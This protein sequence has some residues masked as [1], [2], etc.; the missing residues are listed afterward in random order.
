VSRV[1]TRAAVDL[2][3]ERSARAIDGYP[4]TTGQT[5][6]PNCTSARQPCSPTP[7]PT[8]ASSRSAHAA[9]S[10]D[11]HRFRVANTSAALVA[12][13]VR[14]HILT[15]D[16]RASGVRV[17]ARLVSVL[18][19]SRACVGLADAGH[20]PRAGDRG[21]ARVSER[22]R[23]RQRTGRRI[24]AVRLGTPRSTRTR[25][26]ASSGPSST[27]TSRV[28][29]LLR[30]TCNCSRSSRGS[31]RTRRR[32]IVLGF[33]AANPARVLVDGDHSRDT[34]RRPPQAGW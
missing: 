16:R 29:S 4:M 32:A 27:N 30:P 26:R 7:T 8:P 20:R 1:L 23:L 5:S 3:R 10:R 12:D 15:D 31:W 22:D 6:W 34:P 13:A 17:F 33:P 24:R 21:A 11:A 19:R 25:P 18:H 14:S 28:T 2:A 9:Q